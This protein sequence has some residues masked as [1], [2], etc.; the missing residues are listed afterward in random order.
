MKGESGEIDWSC[1]ENIP[2]RHLKV[3]LWSLGY[4]WAHQVPS[5]SRYYFNKP[6]KA[7]LPFLNI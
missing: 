1:E 4:V 6:L 2:P 7:A 3:P 5:E